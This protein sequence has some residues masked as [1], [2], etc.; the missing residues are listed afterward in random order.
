MIAFLK[1]KRKLIIVSVQLLIIIASIL[2][3]SYAWY[4]NNRDADTQD[5]KVTTYSY[6]DLL[7]SL[8]NG[9]TW[10]TTTSFNIPI[11]FTFN[12]EVTSDGVNFYKA[13]SREADGTPITLGIAENGKD[14]LEFPV[15]FKS[16]GNVGVFLKD[17]STVEPTVGT[18]SDILIG[19]H[20][21]NM[22]SSGSF[23][24]D[25][26]AGSV[27]VA[28]I[29]NDNISGTYVPKSYASMIWAPNSNYEVSCD[30]YTCSASINSTN[31][32]EY[33][34]LDG[35][36]VAGI[37]TKHVSNLRADLHASYEE[38][39]A[40]GDPYITLINAQYNDVTELDEGITKVT[41]RV[42]VEGTDRDTIN[43]LAGGEFN[44]KL[45]FVGI[46]KQI[47]SEIPEVT[48]LGNGIHNYKMSMEYSSDY[49]ISWTKYEDN[50]N[51]L[52]NTGDTVY[53]RYSETETVF[54]SNYKVLNY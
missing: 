33:V 45:D 24:R 54:A 6:V 13:T 37:S 9:A 42:W 25:L 51:P 8:D 10:N 43:A 12:E 53:V 2:V 22:S 49:G 19:N 35:S 3:V 15:L 46:Q 32:Q 1:E 29:E 38:R 47:N 34:Y 23:S 31:S 39:N 14:Y 36:D 17:T 18:T 28:F 40:G 20:A 5:I 52:F 50:G 7:V 4:Y 27:R 16:S 26:I 44:L 11:D 21:S 30:S 41:V 48:I